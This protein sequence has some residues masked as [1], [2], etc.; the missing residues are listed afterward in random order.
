MEISD[1]DEPGRV[2][3]LL[4]ALEEIVSL[5]DSEWMALV[6]G[7]KGKADDY[8]G[9]DPRISLLFAN[10]IV[11]IGEWRDAPGTIALGTMARGD[12]L[13]FLYR[14]R[15]AWETLAQAGALYLEA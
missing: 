12:A 6:E 10:I 5:P 15:Q 1:Y 2:D 7:L 8:W 14:F 13:R 9:R 11:G 4:H 3:R